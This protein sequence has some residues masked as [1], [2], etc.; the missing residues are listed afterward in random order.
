M[1]P[2]LGCWVQLLQEGKPEVTPKQ[3]IRA[4][5]NLKRLYRANLISEDTYFSK[6]DT[7]RQMLVK[8]IY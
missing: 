8:S 6:M 1:V 4:V 2:R 5:Q 7:Y 3:I